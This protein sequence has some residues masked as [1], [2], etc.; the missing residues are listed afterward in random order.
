[1]ERFWLVIAILTAFY[2]VYM[3][4]K[5]GLGESLMYLVFPIIAGAL[6]YLRYYARKRFGRDN[7]ED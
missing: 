2:A 7:S 4:G 5:N 3:V 1:M 6:F